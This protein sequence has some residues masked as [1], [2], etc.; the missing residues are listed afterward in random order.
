MKNVK[1]IKNIISFTFCLAIFCNLEMSRIK[2]MHAIDLIIVSPQIYLT[3][4]T[5]VFMTWPTIL[6]SKSHLL[7]RGSTRMWQRRFTRYCRP[8]LKLEVR[9]ELL[10]FS[11]VPALMS[12]EEVKAC[13]EW[14]LW[15]MSCDGNAL[16]SKKLGTQSTKK[17]NLFQS[18][19]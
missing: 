6:I 4:L 3:Y 11:D 18:H 1:K 15:L 8:M 12:I 5:L 16:V 9:G 14:S 10:L 19:Q 2:L 13:R 17:V 7:V